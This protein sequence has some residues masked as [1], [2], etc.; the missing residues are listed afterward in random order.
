MPGIKDLV[1]RIEGKN[2]MV[3]G[4]SKGIGL[5]AAKRLLQN[6]AKGNEAIGQ[7]PV[8]GPSPDRKEVVSPFVPTGKI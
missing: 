6:I 3:T 2:A 4:V 1:H 5:E 7:E 8:V